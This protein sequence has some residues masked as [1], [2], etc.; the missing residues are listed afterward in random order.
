[1]VAHNRPWLVELVGP[2]GAGKS[3]LARALRARDSRVHTDLCLWGLP[4]RL[5]VT[6]GLGLT[7]AVFSA[8]AGRRPLRSVEILQ[9]AR[10][11]ALRRA[12]DGAMN[13]GYRMILLDEGPIFGLTWFEVFHARNGDPGWSPW[14]KQAVR[15]WASR[16]DAVVQLDAADEVLAQRIKER[17]QGHLVKYLPDAQIREFSDR[18]RVGFDRII[19]ELT[20][21]GRPAV[22][23]LR[24]DQASAP[25]AA[26]RLL[27]SLGSLRSGH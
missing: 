24:T 25:E 27:A 6:S 18:Y 2:A 8:A 4:R 26:A 16:I 17:E 20:D 9:M 7:S 5:L 10:L 11:G 1:M 22:L 14:R 3:T 13:Q 15:D 12:I 19:A 23:H 21:N